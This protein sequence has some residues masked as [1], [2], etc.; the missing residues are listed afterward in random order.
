MELVKVI[1]QKK[2]ETSIEKKNTNYKAHSITPLYVTR[3]H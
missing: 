2:S 3:Q 1:K